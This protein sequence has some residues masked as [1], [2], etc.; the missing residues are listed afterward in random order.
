MTKRVY[1]DE[2]FGPQSSPIPRNPEQIRTE[3]DLSPEQVMRAPEFRLGFDDVRAGRPA[4]FDGFDDTN[5]AWQ[6]ERGRQ[7]ATIAPLSVKLRINGELN[8]RALRLFEATV[9]RGD[10]Q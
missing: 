9:G 10:I 4:R 3:D 8:P 6:Y 2:R 5:G 1:G 7:F